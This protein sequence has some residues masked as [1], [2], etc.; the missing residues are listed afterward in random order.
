[1]AQ[2]LITIATDFTDTPGPRYRDEGPFSGEQFREEML[3]PALR[4]GDSLFLDLDETEGYGSS[5]L[6]EAF[7]GLVRIDRFEPNDLL[8]RLS[9][10][11]A[12]ST[13]VTQITNYIRE[14]KPGEGARR[15]KMRKNA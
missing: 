6:E 13:Y 7:G 10:K 15:Q 11:S 8:Q 1:M 4:A 3:V 9:F 12:D 2:R 5:F 14:A